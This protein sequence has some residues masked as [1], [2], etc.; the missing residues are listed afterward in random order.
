MLTGV[1]Y[2]VDDLLPV[3]AGWI[4]NFLNH[5]SVTVGEGSRHIDNCLQYTR[6]LNAKD[7]VTGIAEAVVPGSSALGRV[8]PA[9]HSTRIT[10]DGYKRSQSKKM[11]LNPLICVHNL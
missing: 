5:W 4:N 8:S 10:R 2:H 7:S 11:Y 1:L 9:N 6:S 3:V